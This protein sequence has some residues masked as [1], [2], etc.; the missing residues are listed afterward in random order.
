MIEGIRKQ[1]IVVW[2]IFKA[3]KSSWSGETRI[4]HA[5]VYLVIDMEDL[6]GVALD[7]AG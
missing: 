2:R 4:T 5:I 7:A 6:A 3:S 1:A